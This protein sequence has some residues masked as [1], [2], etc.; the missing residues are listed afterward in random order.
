MNR[1]QE[2]SHPEWPDSTL[3]PCTPCT[4]FLVDILGP[5]LFCDIPGLRYIQGHC[6]QTPQ[7]QYRQQQLECQESKRWANIRASCSQA[8]VF[9]KVQRRTTM[10]SCYRPSKQAHFPVRPPLC[11]VCKQTASTQTKYA[12]RHKTGKI[13]TINQHTSTI[14]R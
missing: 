4:T 2:N 13:M 8:Q 7:T 3:H 12:C 1:E 6:N 9:M 14:L 10:A 11:A 5:P